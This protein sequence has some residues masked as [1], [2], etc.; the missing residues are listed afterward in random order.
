MALLY[1][2]QQ[3]LSSIFI[4]ESEGPALV[5]SG[6]SLG[7]GEGRPHPKKKAAKS[8]PAVFG[9]GPAAGIGASKTKNGPIGPALGVPVRPRATPSND[10]PA[11]N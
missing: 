11:T 10:S 1:L 3:L 6:G 4:P 7:L 8:A 2:E 5:G 9:L